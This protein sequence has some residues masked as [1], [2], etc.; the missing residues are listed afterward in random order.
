MIQ[1]KVKSFFHLRD[2]LRNGEVDLQV[3]AG[4]T[5]RDILDELIRRFGEEIRMA[6]IDP[7]SG[8]VRPYY[9]V[10]IGGR[11]LHQL[12]DLDTPLSDGDVIAL[13]P[14]VAG[15]RKGVGN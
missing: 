12:R 10:L 1:V 13:F 3:E 2:L 15:G 6:L 11:D 14:P 5:V 4:A 8:R 9:R 7:Q